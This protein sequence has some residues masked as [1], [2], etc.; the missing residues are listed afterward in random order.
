MRF[1]TAGARSRLRHDRINTL[2]YGA[3]GGPTDYQSRARGN[4]RD[5]HARSNCAGSR[6]V[7]DGWAWNE[8]TGVY[9]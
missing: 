3:G 1:A 5:T 6:G 4:A 9:H 8:T 7:H 2:M